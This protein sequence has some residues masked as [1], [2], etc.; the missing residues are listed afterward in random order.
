MEC[1]YADTKENIASI[2]RIKNLK[3]QVSVLAAEIE[4][5]DSDMEK[6]TI[7]GVDIK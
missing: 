2:E 5:C 3:A 4:K 6:V 7:P 1:C